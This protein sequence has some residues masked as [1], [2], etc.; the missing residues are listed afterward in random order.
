MSQ[1]WS[2]KHIGP[3]QPFISS[4]VVEVD[5]VQVAVDEQHDGEAD[6]DLGG[7]DGDHEQREHLADRRAVVERAERDEVDVHR[8][9][10]QLDRHQH[11]HRVLAGE[12]AVDADAEQERAEQEELVEQHRRQSF[13][14]RT[15]APIERGEQEH[16]DATSNG[17]R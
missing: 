10:D 17:M 13:R 5:A 4:S 11:E 3:A 1:A 16:D 8:V 14:A 9:E 15:M 2:R 12:H 7:G 6:A